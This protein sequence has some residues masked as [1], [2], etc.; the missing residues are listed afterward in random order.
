V[1]SEMRAI[2]GLTSEPLTTGIT[3]NTDAR[4]APHHHIV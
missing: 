3:P 2:V 4:S 1:Q